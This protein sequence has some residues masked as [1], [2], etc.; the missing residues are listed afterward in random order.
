MAFFVQNCWVKNK[1]MAFHSVVCRKKKKKDKEK[2]AKKILEQISSVTD[3]EPGSSSRQPVDR[4]TKAEKAFDK[5][6][7]K[8]VRWN[9][10]R[11]F[12]TTVYW[13]AMNTNTFEQLLLLL[14]CKSWKYP[15]NYI[16][17]PASLHADLW[18]QNLKDLCS[19]VFKMI[20][21]TC[22]T[23]V[24]AWKQIPRKK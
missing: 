14:F 9:C 11:A 23:K 5:V 18:I 7:E 24:P 15:I 19:N 2:E 22:D 16:I 13:H 6:K 1:H 4:R 21:V 10:K 8:R 3:T 12:V 17:K 20:S